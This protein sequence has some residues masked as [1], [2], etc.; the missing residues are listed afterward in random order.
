MEGAGRRHRV[1]GSLRGSL[2]TVGL[3]EEGVPGLEPGPLEGRD[4]D[5]QAGRVVRPPDRVSPVPP[6]DPGRLGVP[7]RG[8]RRG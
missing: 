8:P 1:Q 6:E 3:T 4:D 7:Q 5:R 2:Q